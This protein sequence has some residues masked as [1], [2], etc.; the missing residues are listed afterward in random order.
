M[1]KRGQVTLFIIV[2]IV[3]ILLVVLAVSFR[4]ELSDFFSDLTG[5]ETIVAEQLQPI[6]NYLDTCLEDVSLEAIELLAAQ[7]GYIH[8]PKDK[9]PIS[10]R[11][12]FSNYLELLP[13][14]NVVYWFYEDG[15]G[16]QLNQVP[17]IQGME[18]ELENYIVDKFQECVEGTNT[19]K[20]LG[21]EIEISDNARAEVDIA[22]ENVQV[23]VRRTINAEYKGVGD[24]WS[25]HNADVNVPLG[26]VYEA[27]LDVMNKENEEVWLENATMNYIILYDF[28]YSNVEFTCSAKIWNKQDLE[29][30]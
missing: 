20:E 7:G 1:Q 15:V 19:Y 4:S 29:N 22:R 12:I 9:Y 18:Q 27:A 11:N 8:I 30:D 25:R 10:V 13:G 6:Q 28:P 21:Y 14:V 17:T 3:I 16:N 23:Q 5:S 24:R 2:G 26:E